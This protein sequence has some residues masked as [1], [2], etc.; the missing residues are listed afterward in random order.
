MSS[1]LSVCLCFAFAVFVNGQ[2]TVVNDRTAVKSS[3]CGQSPGIST[4]KTTS[5]SGTFDG[6]KRKW[7]V[8]LPSN[9]DKNTAFVSPVWFTIILFWQSC[10]TLANQLRNEFAA[11]V[12]C[13]IYYNHFL[14]TI[15]LYKKMTNHIFLLHSAALLV[16]TH[17]WGGRWRPISYPRMVIISCL[18][19]PFYCIHNFSGSQDES[20][21]GLSTASANGG[22]FIAV[23]PDGYADNSNWGSWGSWN[24]VG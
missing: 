7:R 5:M 21:S 13:M 20:S 8:Y 22:N 12:S 4:G 18:F 1:A 10:L 16:S 24:C 17:G 11:R 23:F 14:S 6:T 9:Y 19:S 3:G 2:R 15:V